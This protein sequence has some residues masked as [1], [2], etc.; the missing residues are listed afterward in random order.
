MVLP[1]DLHKVHGF[2]KVT[3]YPILFLDV[4]E[5]NDETRRQS[6]P[7]PKVTEMGAFA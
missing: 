5:P 3:Q 6:V 4:R 1:F 2:E 7:G